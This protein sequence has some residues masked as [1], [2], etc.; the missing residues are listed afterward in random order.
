[1][2]LRFHCHWTG[3]WLKIRCI[4]CQISKRWSSNR[5][6]SC[7]CPIFRPTRFLDRVLVV[8][9]FRDQ[10]L[11]LPP[12]S[13]RWRRNRNIVQVSVLID[14]LSYNLFFGEIY[15]YF[16]AAAFK[17]RSSQ[18]RKQQNFWMGWNMVILFCLRLEIWSWKLKFVCCWWFFVDVFCAWLSYWWI[19][20]L[21]WRMYVIL[22]CF[23]RSDPSYYS[24]FTCFLMK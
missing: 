12:H 9:R 11:V 23:L 14:F 16:L 10:V 7:R 2:C 19:F 22:C 8:T 4:L 3:W 21:S 13:N 17:S 20:F 15:S 24:S 18:F 6:R 1:M 5:F